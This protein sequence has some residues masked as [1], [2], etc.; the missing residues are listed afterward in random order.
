MSDNNYNDNTSGSVAKDDN[1]ASNNSNHVNHESNV[2][3]SGIN[4]VGIDEISSNEVSEAL[5]V[6]DNTVTGIVGKAKQGLS[7][8]EQLLDDMEDDEFWSLPAGEWEK[9][10]NRDENGLPL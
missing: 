7:M 1:S 9:K 8:L 6:E 5:P 3:E 4:E 2:N 10:N